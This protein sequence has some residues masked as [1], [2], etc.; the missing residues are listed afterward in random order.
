MTISNRNNYC[1]YTYNVNGV[2][3]PNCTGVRDLGV[4][5]NNR[6]KYNEHVDVITAK[7]RQRVGLLFKCFVTRDALTLTKA[8]VT[9]VRPILEY[10][11]V[12]WNS[13]SVILLHKIESVQRMF[14]RRLRGLDGL[15]YKDRNAALNLESLELR[16]LKADLIM[17]YKVI[18]GLIDLDVKHFFTLRQGSVTRG[19]SYKI[20]ADKYTVRC[21]QN[22]FSTRVTNAW[23]S[24][25]RDIVNFNNLDMFVR[26]LDSIDFKDYVS[27]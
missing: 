20:L 11:S 25:P 26:S 21:R 9:Y 23:N 22:F 3:L 4:Y 27:F 12:I 5:I 1:S 7:A 2:A 18:F 6:L 8:Y 16:R 17:A 10:A 19:H 15:S 13:N 14:T 24:L